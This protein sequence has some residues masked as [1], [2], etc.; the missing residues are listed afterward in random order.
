MEKTALVLGGG[1]A[2]G[3][4]EVGVWQALCELDVPVDIVT[5]TSVGALNAAVIA[6]GS[7]E[8]VSALWR[9][10]RTDMVRHD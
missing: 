9:N 2:R 8:S 1:G 4:Y 10:L 7:F 5:G 6:A 3:A